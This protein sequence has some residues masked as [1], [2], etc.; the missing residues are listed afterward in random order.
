MVKKRKLSPKHFFI[1]CVPVRVHLCHTDST[2]TLL[3]PVL[4]MSWTCRPSSY[5]V[6]VYTFFTHT[7]LYLHLGR[8]RSLFIRAGHWHTPTRI[9]CT[10]RRFYPAVL[11]VIPADISPI[12]FV[13]RAYIP[14]THHTIYYG[15]EAHHTYM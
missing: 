11:V 13:Y 6:V 14:P 2:C 10:G 4:C 5:T 15:A 9:V 7:D 8:I 3:P 1:V 12:D